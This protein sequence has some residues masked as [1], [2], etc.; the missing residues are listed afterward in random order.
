MT[1]MSAARGGWLVRLVLLT[2]TLI[3]LTAMHSLGHQPAM[4][5]Q[6]HGSAVPASTHAETPPG[7]VLTTAIAAMDVAVPHGCA[8][9]QCAGLDAAP[10][11]AP[12]HMPG[13]AVC[14]A[15][16]GAFGVSL[17]LTA[18]LL[19]RRTGAMPRDRRQPSV[20]VSRGP[21]AW[22]PMGQRVTAVSVLR[23]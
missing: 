23:I 3:G 20:A 22:S 8:G 13:W 2:A 5:G 7:A 17:A 12:G 10:S 11:G 9:G 4:T 15:V 18:A 19:L 14:L 1:G 21:P 6:H 16:V